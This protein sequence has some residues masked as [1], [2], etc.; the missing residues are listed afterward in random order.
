MTHSRTNRHLNPLA[1]ARAQSLV[2]FALT[3]PL[4]SLLLLGTV[5][6]GRVFKLYVTITNAS[7]EGARYGIQNPADT[8]GIQAHAIQ[9]ASSSGVLLTPSDIT[10]ACSHYGG[11]SS[12]ACDAA[13]NGDYL[14]V[15]VTQ[16]F[17]LLS[18][19]DRASIHLS[20]FTVMPII[21]GVTSP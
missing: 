4:L 7:R 6:L 8:P 10:V 11:G 17:H 15:T 21:N 2:E 18:L 14:Q 12:V 19:L 16:D 20:S 1:S 5:D 9:E 3:L 13:Y